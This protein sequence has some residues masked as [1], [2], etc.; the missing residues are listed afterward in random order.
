MKFTNL[1][2]EPEG[3]LRS[4]L[5][6]TLDPEHIVFLPDACPGNS[7][8]PTGTAVFTRQPNW[9]AFA[10]SDCGCGMRLLK[11]SFESNNLTPQIWDETAQ[12]I[13]KNKGKLGDLGGGNHFL[14]A[15][16]PYDED[17]LYFLIH[18]GSR[19]ESGIVDDL[20]NNHVEFDREFDRIVDWAKANRAKVQ[21][22]IENF[23][24]PTELI[25]DLPHNTYEKREQGTLIRKGSVKLMPGDLSILP[26]HMSGDVSLIK[27]LPSIK[28]ILFSMSHGTGRTMSRS[29]A[30]QAAVSFDFDILRK[31][32]LMPS[33]LNNASLNTEGP[34]AYR[35][36]DDC[37][38]LISGYVIEIKRFSVVAYAGHL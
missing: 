29:D 26:S 14:N 32:I 36:L 16:L 30:K 6:H 24:G 22:T 2:A 3:V 4:W 9:R 19:Q 5:P 17:S 23:I 21:E 33:F 20:I 1:S 28:N 18:T 31:M 7:P 15:L 34:F 37:L 11:S 35:D 8:L 10:V 25:L 13:R 12:A 38:A 27:A